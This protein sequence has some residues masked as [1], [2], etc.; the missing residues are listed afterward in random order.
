MESKNDK[1]NNNPVKCKFKY[2]TKYSL[3]EKKKSLNKLRRD[4]RG[5]TLLNKRK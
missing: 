4:L 1:V 5:H 2:K 3:K